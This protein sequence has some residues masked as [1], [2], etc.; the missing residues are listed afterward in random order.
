MVDNHTAKEFI[1]KA[2]TRK[3]Q[4]NNFISQSMEEAVQYLAKNIKIEKLDVQTHKAI[5]VKEMNLE[6]MKRA[7][8]CYLV[9]IR[10]E[11]IDSGT[12]IINSLLYENTKDGVNDLCASVEQIIGEKKISLSDEQKRDERNP[13]IAEQIWHMILV[14]T[15]YNQAIY[16]PGKIIGINLAHINAKDHGLDGV[17]IFLTPSDELGL[18]LIESKAY[19]DNYNM[20][21]TNAID[22]F[23]KVELGKY[24]THIRREITS[25]RS[26][27]NPIYQKKISPSFWKDTKSYVPNPHYDV[28]VGANWKNQRPS[29]SSLDIPKDYK[30]IMPHEIK[31]FDR[32]FEDVAGFMRDFCKECNKY[33]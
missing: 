22:F 7:I 30:I 29:F 8:A 16:P 1:M 12:N 33:V 20:A 31:D 3:V 32:F 4:L 11:A 13:W 18:V 26:N 28:R 25:M 24:N 27:L 10:A 6:P 9:G 21:I 17:G 15:K 23:K 19:K 2:K 5:T 14:A